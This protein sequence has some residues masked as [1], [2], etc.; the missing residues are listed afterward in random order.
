MGLVEDA[1]D[2]E[3]LEPLLAFERICDRNQK[4]AEAHYF[5]VM[6]CRKSG[7]KAR[8][9]SRTCDDGHTT[10]PKAISWQRLIPLRRSSP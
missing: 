8:V 7:C 5:R 9:K 3:A 6:H 1:T 4:Q 10:G 2:E